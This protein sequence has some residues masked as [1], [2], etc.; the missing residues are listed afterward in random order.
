MNIKSQP[1]PEL[2]AYVRASLALAGY[3]FDE[4]TIQAVTAEFLRVHG[5]AQPLLDMN[6]PD[7][8]EPAPVF[9]P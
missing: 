7:A 9:R 4:S 6:L 1:P 2:E 5:I 8:L 3:S